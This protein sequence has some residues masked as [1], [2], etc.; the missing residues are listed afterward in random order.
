MILL[1]PM[2]GNLL[3]EIAGTY[4][5]FTHTTRSG[6]SVLISNTP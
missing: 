1:D 5:F 4:L 2:P 6:F 3:L